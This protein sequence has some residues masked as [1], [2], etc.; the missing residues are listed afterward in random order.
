MFN[1]WNGRNGGLESAFCRLEQGQ[2]DYGVLQGIKITDIVYTQ[3]YSSFWLMEMAA[4]SARHGGGAIFYRKAEKID[5]KE[6]R[7]HGPNVIIF[8]LVTGQRW[9]HVAGCYTAP[10]NTY[11]IEN[12]T[13][14][15][16]DQP[17][18]AELLAA[19]DF[20]TNLDEPKGTP[21][22]GGDCG[23]AC[24]GG[25]SVHLVALPTTA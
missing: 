16:R 12:V 20:N 1:I 23:R 7:L 22:G 6:L 15:I 10:V 11:T 14:S 2:V 25:D 9:W 4:L 13:F 5:I 19:G 24:D 18:G 3:E 8:Q 21:Q 17:Y